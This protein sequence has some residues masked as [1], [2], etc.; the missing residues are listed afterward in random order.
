MNSKVVYCVNPR[1][2]RP[3]DTMPNSDNAADPICTCR[4]PGCRFF[5][6]T[7]AQSKLSKMSPDDLLA[8]LKCRF[9]T[10]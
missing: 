7:E 10:K 3:V 5:N 6:I 8:F 2:N 4:N 9:Q 1:C